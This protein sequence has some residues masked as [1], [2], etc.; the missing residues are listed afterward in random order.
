[1]E[2][3]DDNKNKGSFWSNLPE[4]IKSIATIL[5][6]IGG[7]AGLILALNQ[8]G[9]F[10]QFRPAPTPTST[11][12]PKFGWAVSFE[13]EFEQGFWKPGNNSYETIVDC[14]DIAAFG[15]SDNRIEFSVDEKAPLFPDAVV[16]FHYFGIPS[17]NKGESRLT[18]INP[19]Q[20]TK[21]DFGYVNISLEQAQQAINECQAKAIINDQGTIQL[22]PIGPL[23]AN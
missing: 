14:P 1:M 16:E 5:T 18:S 17:P 4:I 12:V 10:D 8:I 15:D 20:K 21:I 7:L 3:Q 23:P 6:A 2:N 9:A 19:N 22:S 13:Y 11:P